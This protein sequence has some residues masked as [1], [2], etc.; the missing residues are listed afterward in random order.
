MFNPLMNTE[1]GMTSFQMINYG[2]DNRELLSWWLFLSQ[3]EAYYLY[4]SIISQY[5]AC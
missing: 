2:Q 1:S 5:E 3:K 4:R